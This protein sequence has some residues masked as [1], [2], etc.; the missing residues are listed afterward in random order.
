MSGTYT[1]IAVTQ[2]DIDRALRRKSGRCVVATAVARSI[3]DATR[4]EVDLQTVRFTADG[5]RRVYL[6]PPA[7]SG[8]VVAFDA[9][10][11]IH[12]FAFKLSERQ[13]VNVRQDKHT[14]AAKER[15]RVRAAVVGK[16]K[17]L[18]RAQLR[19]EELLESPVADADEIAVATKKVKTVSREIAAAKKEHEKTKEQL[20]GLPY[21]VPDMTPDPDTGERLRK[22]PVRAFKTATRTYGSRQLRVNQARRTAENLAAK[23]A[24]TLE[25]DLW[26]GDEPVD[27]DDT[28]D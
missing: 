18:E 26:A 21:V 8:Y 24:L 25:Y 6:T 13:R 12:P 14:P 20:Q 5:E 4:V 22:P 17:K 19:L 7:A 9:G 27:D 3:P 11:D 28:S 23:S 1:T 2:D 16:Q 15:G 10:D